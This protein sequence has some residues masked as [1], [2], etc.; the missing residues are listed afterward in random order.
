M[1]RVLPRSSGDKNVQR[2]QARGGQPARTHDLDLWL[3]AIGVYFLTV[4]EPEV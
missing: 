1:R 3:K 4:L 2:T